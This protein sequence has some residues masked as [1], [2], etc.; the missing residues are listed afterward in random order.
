LRE[1]D[2]LRVFE[3]RMLRRIFG[4]MK[5]KITRGWRKLLNEELHIYSSPDIIRMFQSR[6]MRRAEHVACVGWSACRVL[7]R[8][9]ERKRLIGRHRRRW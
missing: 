6:R 7:V 8:K 1:E 4:T 5:G 2:R 3:N 9:P